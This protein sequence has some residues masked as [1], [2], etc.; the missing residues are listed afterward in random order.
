MKNKED[1]VLDDRVN[2]LLKLEKVKNI[3]CRGAVLYVVG[4][5]PEPRE[6]DRWEFNQ[7]LP[8]GFEKI[9]S[10]E[11]GCFAVWNHDHYFAAQVCVVLDAEQSEPVLLFQDGYGGVFKKGR[12]SDTMMNRA[13]DCYIGRLS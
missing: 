8:E 7:N 11:R 4:A 13:P 10:P 5:I 2:N 3:N 9:T 6:L 1:I 12:Y